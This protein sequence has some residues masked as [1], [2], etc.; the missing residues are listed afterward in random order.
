MLLLLTY[1]NWFWPSK[2]SKK[3][4]AYIYQTANDQSESL[5]NLYNNLNLKLELTF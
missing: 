5:H 3:T 1:M 4:I 2:S